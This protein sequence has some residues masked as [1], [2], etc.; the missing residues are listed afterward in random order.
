[1]NNRVIN[2]FMEVTGTSKPT[3][4]KYLKQYEYNFNKAL[5]QYLGKRTANK[6]LLVLYE[7][8]SQLDQDS[9]GESIGIEGTLQYLTDLGIEP[10]DIRSLVL[11]YFLQ[12]D[13]MGIIGKDQFLNNW[14]KVRVFNIK[15]M[16]TY[17]DELTQ[18]MHL[19]DKF[20]DLYAY[21]FNFLLES[22]NQKLI[23]GD[24]VVDYWKL[25]FSLLPPEISQNHELFERINQLYDFILEHD[26]KISKDTYLMIWE[27]IKEVVIPDPKNLSAYDEMSSWPV[28]IDEFIEHLQ[29]K[30]LLDV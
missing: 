19:I 14:D 29:E 3:A 27:F 2:D 26:K 20:N 11:S 28:L 12:S 16:V 23:N 30:K 9:D 24:I 7:K 17:I 22:P 4:T 6:Q 8:Y 5:D 13:S 15:D 10:E 18:Q 1:M 25:L 21:T